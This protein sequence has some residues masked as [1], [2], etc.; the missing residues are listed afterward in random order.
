MVDDTHDPKLRVSSS[1]QTDA[2][3]S[4]LTSHA[5]A[6]AIRRELKSSFPRIRPWKVSRIARRAGLKEYPIELMIPGSTRAGG[7]GERAL[8][9]RVIAAR[10][11]RPSSNHPLFDDTYYLIANPDVAMGN[12]V[13]W[14]HYQLYGRLEGRSPHPLISTRTLGEQMQGVPLSAVVDEFLSNQ[15]WWVCS[16]SP[17]VD[18]ARFMLHGP[19]DHK[20]S[21]FAQI[22]TDQVVPPWVRTD[23][24]EI[25]ASIEDVG[26]S[27][28]GLAASRILLDVGTRRG[29]VG[30]PLARLSI[31]TLGEKSN[32]QPY[33]VVPG[34]FV[35]EDH[36]AQ[37]FNGGATGKSLD[38]SAFVLANEVLLRRPSTETRAN[39][40]ALVE[41][42]AAR[43]DILKFLN[44]AQGSVALAM[45]SRL[46]ESAV[47]ALLKNVGNSDAFVLPW[48]EQTAVLCDRLETV[49]PSAL[50]PPLPFKAL[51]YDFPAGETCVVAPW[52]GRGQELA[53]PQVKALLEQGAQLCLVVE[54]D[55]SNWATAILG[56]GRLIVHQTCVEAVMLLSPPP[57]AGV[58]T[59]S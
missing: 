5:V 10:R 4:S 26:N 9:N 24:L 56:A 55:L 40:L 28:A 29:G 51:V 54:E 30:T 14:L 1:T 11:R 42:R 27:D 31:G 33:R 41:S 6:A 34:M 22:A 16:P 43:A 13:P 18:V 17:Y 49:R 46:Q 8:W 2:P 58:W 44:G 20:N 25:D 48:G 47:E 35:A 12:V 32:G 39:T 36:A 21:P 37:L 53:P 59:F 50:K 7:K 38:G 23:L 19:W 15:K 3:A 45:S 52:Y 57:R